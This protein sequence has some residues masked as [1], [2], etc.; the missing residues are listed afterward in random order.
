MKIAGTIKSGSFLAPVMIV[1]VTQG[2]PLYRLWLGTV[3]ILGGGDIR[4]G[5]S[6]PGGEFA[7]RIEIYTMNP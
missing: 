3:I 6:N 5:W 1:S 2:D 7:P 4:E